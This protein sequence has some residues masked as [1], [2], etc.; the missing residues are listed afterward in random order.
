MCSYVEHTAPGLLVLDII[1]FS[2]L[3]PGQ[4]VVKGRNAFGF[5][6]FTGVPLRPSL[7]LGFLVRSGV[8]IK[9][10]LFQKGGFLWCEYRYLGPGVEDLE[11]SSAFRG[12]PVTSLMVA[13]LRFIV[14][15]SFPVHIFVSF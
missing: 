11:L 14:L 15:A 13:R 4:G 12:G 1:S 10:N 8:R 6:G 3:L 5:W 2:S 9:P 7:R